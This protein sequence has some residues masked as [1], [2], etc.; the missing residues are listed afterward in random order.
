MELCE[1]INLLMCL[2][3]AGLMQWPDTILLIQEVPGL[4]QPVIAFTL[5]NSGTI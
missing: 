5:Q 1:G 3:S 2:N 4:V